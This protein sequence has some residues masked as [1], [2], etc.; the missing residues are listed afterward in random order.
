M[1]K[2]GN[3]VME[4]SSRGLIRDYAES[5]AIRV[6]NFEAPLP[7]LPPKMPVPTYLY[8][9]VAMLI[10]DGIDSRGR[11]SETRLL[12]HDLPPP[13]L[14]DHDLPP[15]RLLDHDLSPPRLLDHE[16]SPMIFQVM[17]QV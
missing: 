15:P 7:I 3:M 16:L 6:L 17:T 10:I 1:A 13:R 14:L 11:T 12:D 5:L 8:S 2:Q 4:S 9:P